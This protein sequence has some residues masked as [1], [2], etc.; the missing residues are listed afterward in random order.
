MCRLS[1]KRRRRRR[2]QRNGGRNGD[3]V[4]VRTTGGFC[5]ISERCCGICKWRRGCRS[6][7]ITM[8][9]WKNLEVCAIIRESIDVDKGR[10]TGRYQN[11]QRERGTRDLMGRGISSEN[12]AR[13]LRDRDIQVD[14]IRISG[15]GRN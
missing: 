3:V 13:S 4:D 12:I 7:K 8:L 6:G 14:W 15:V 5:S 9:D 2:H 11:C 10:R 1:D